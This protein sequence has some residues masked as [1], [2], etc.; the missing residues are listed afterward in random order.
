MDDTGTFE[1]STGDTGSVKPVDQDGDGYT[2]GEDCDDSDPAV[3]P[4]AGDPCDGID[5]DCDGYAAPN[6]VPSEYA[7]IGEAV[8]ALPDG[9]EIC[10]EPGTYTE[11]LDL[12]GRDL[13]I[14]SQLGSSVTVL[15]LGGD[16]PLIT[17]DNWDE[18]EGA[19]GDA[20]GVLALSGLTVTGGVL[21]VNEE[22]GSL[23][24]GLL[25]L[26]GSTADLRDIEVGAIEAT[27]SH[28]TELSGLLVYAEG[29]QLSIDGLRVSGLDFAFEA[30]DSFGSPVLQGGV[31]YAVD[32]QVELSD[33]E[34]QD[35]WT[36][37]EGQPWNCRVHGAVL[38]L[39]S[40]GLVATELS[41]HDNFGAHN[42]AYYHM[43]E[44]WLVHLEQSDSTV[45]QL[46]VTGN[47]LEVV[48]VG[49]GQAY[50]NGLVH[51][52]EAPRVTQWSVIDISDN[53]QSTS[54]DAYISEASGTLRSLDPEASF[55]FLTMHRN[56]V[57]AEATGTSAYGYASC[58]GLEAWNGGHFD[59]LDVRGNAV[60][61]TKSA[62]G[63]G[64][65]LS[66]KD[67]F[68]SGATLD[69]FV[70]AGNTV[71]GGYAGGIGGGMHLQ[72]MNGDITL[73]QGDVVGNLLVSDEEAVGGGLYIYANARGYDG[74][75]T[76][77]GVNIVGNSAYGP[78]GVYGTAVFLVDPDA[79]VDWRYSNV[80]GHDGE[81]YEGLE[82]PSGRQGNLA[83]DPLYLD[84]SV[85]DPVGW[86][87][88]L[89]AGSPAIDAGDPSSLDADGSACDIGAYGGP[90][91]AEW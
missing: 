44:G 84:T 89:G 56:S 18:E 81:P 79:P 38:G 29:A 4:G 61:G 11:R 2:A 39:Q 76:V 16:L 12:T 30:D 68:T 88:H 60:D 21:T 85:T 37:S 27:L 13:S 65:C 51:V 80:F 20:P 6:L 33:V 53:D 52:G 54:N 7:S 72:L 70:V 36:R 43:N 22:A 41:L 17:V 24:G 46:R 48:S 75:L 1:P 55:S 86:D 59:H 82:D 25:S 50:A 42:P 45:E 90:T 23:L 74:V 49:G 69:S 77:S 73:L 5:Q 67:P 3:H 28:D 64:I 78:E 58:G 62:H 31:V 19:A 63:G 91:G 87:L 15:D 71:E 26:R 34:V 57:R 40:S 35:L 14:T 9:S 83:L 66:G 10:L 47:S 32:S 8:A